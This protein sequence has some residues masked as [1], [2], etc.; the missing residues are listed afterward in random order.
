MRKKNVSSGAG[1][2]YP[3]VILALILCGTGALFGILS[4]RATPDESANS[5]QPANGA[6]V[7]ASARNDVFAGVSYKNDT[8]APLRDLPIPP[9]QW[10]AQHQSGWAIQ[11]KLISVAAL[12]SPSI[13]VP[14]LN[15]EGVPIGIGG[16]ILPPDPDGAAG[17]TQY[18]QAVNNGF[19]VFDKATGASVLGPVPLETLWAGF[20]GVCQPGDTFRPAWPMVLYDQL[21]NRWVIARSRSPSGVATDVCMA[22][23]TTSDATGSYHRYGFVLGTNNFFLPQLSLWPDGY[24]M[25]TEVYNSLGSAYLGP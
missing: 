17:L 25:G 13:P 23:S 22:V 14:I 8:S 5:A 12:L 16:S 3:R 2:F 1:F 18:V 24:Y 11:S 21:A 9:E 10:K 15:F 7:G 6:V 4:G 19:Q 20:G